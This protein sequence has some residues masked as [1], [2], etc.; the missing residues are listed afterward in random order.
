MNWNVKVNLN[1]III[2]RPHLYNNNNK[3][4]IVILMIY[5]LFS[6]ARKE[7][8]TRSR[9]EEERKSSN[10][11]SPSSSTSP[12]DKDPPKSDI[13]DS[14]LPSSCPNDEDDGFIL[15]GFDFKSVLSMCQELAS[16][17]DDDGDPVH[18]DSLYKAKDTNELKNALISVLGIS[19][20]ETMA[21][22]TR[23]GGVPLSPVALTTP[24]QPGGRALTLDE[25]EGQS[26]SVLTSQ[27][28]DDQSAFNK[29]LA[30]LNTT[31]TAT[32]AVPSPQEMGQ[33]Y[34]GQN[35]C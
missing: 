35:V 16:D 29:F 23:G 1:T 32:T 5:C 13:V 11:G 3:N 7:A 12:L 24:S 26:S 33:Q 19:K 22:R 21:M 18:K 6:T 31:N 10:D 4:N 28:D 8:E 30:T 20:E 2:A 14:G 34:Q 9:D 27:G 15:D 17:S 25:I